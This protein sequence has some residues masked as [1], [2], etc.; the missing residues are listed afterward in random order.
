MMNGFA[1]DFQRFRQSGRI[2]VVEPR[3]ECLLDASWV[4]PGAPITGRVNAFECR[5]VSLSWRYQGQQVWR[6]AVLNG[7]RFILPG[8]AQAGVLELKV[9]GIDDRDSESTA[10]RAEVH[11]HW[12]AAEVCARLTNEVAVRH[13]A[14]QLLVDACWVQNLQISLDGRVISGGVARPGDPIHLMVDVPTSE[15]GHFVLALEWHSLDGRHG[16]QRLAYEVQPR[17][18]TITMRAQP[19]G[20]VSYST[21]HATSLRLRIPDRGIE[22]A[23]P[24]EGVVE[25]IFLMPTAGQIEF[26]DEAGQRQVRALRFDYAPGGWSPLPGFSDR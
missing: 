7:T 8:V 2:G 4:I 21:K 1:A 13:D 11:V 22:M 20:G 14:I 10:A 17:R 25:D 19:Q 12:P 3:V 23:I 5:A 15:M 9:I 26:M 24:A 6:Q 18:G 16:A